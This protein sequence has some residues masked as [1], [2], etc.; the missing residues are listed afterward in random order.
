MW[1][2][3]GESM[4]RVRSRR[5]RVPSSPKRVRPAPRTTGAMWICSASASPAP[6]GLL[7][8][9]GSAA[10]GDQPVS[11]DLPSPID[12]CHHAVDEFETRLGVGLLIHP[13]GDHYAWTER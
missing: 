2:A 9:A 5:T 6:Q 1:V 12:R 7:H 8:D 13:V 3:K 4:T 11:G 10:D